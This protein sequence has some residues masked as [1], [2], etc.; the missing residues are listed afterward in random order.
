MR[1]N[2]IIYE[3]RKGIAKITLNR[4]ESLNAVNG[5][6]ALEIGH[7]LKDAERDRKIRVVVVTGYGKAFCAG[8]DLNFVQEKAKSLLE[9]QELFLL[10][11]RTITDAIE[12]LTKPVIAAVNGQAMGGGYELMLACDFAI[13]SEKAVIADQHINFGLI[14]PGGSTQRTSRIVGIRKAKEIILTGEQFSGAEAESIGLVNRAVP[15]E[16]LE[17]AVTELA[18]K[19]V[20]KS[21]TAMRIGKA[22]INRAMQTDLGTAQELEVASALVNAASD[23]YKEGMRAFQEKR[24]PVFKGR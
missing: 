12:R 20:D 11:N 22:L 7:A 24:K 1:Y 16:S 15:P 21:P 14:G 17:S 18:G 6:M 19:L 2:H 13:A 5:R 3:K 10:L 4:P 9:Q 8:V 23:D